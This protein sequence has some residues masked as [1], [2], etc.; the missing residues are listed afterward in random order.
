MSATTT[1]IQQ[2]MRLGSTL[3]A[4]ILAAIVLGAAL[5][6]A[7]LTAKTNSGSA[8]PAPNAPIVRDLGAR[9]QSGPAGLAPATVHDTGARDTSGQP[10]AGTSSASAV[11]IPVDLRHRGLRAQ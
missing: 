10:I 1:T 6:F 9:E 7:G 3:V 4:A 8:V 2:P 5:A 11:R